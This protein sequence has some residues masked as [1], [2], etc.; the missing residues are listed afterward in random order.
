MKFNSEDWCRR[1]KLAQTDKEMT[2][3]LMELANKPMD[4]ILKERQESSCMP[5][6]PS[7]E[8]EILNTRKGKIVVG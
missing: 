5:P 7:L 6:H 1:V 3:L 2:A 4:M 8:P